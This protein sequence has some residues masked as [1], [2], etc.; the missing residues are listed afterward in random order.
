M[1]ASKTSASANAGLG[2]FP[3]D[4]E[5]QSLLSSKSGVVAQPVVGGTLPFLSFSNLMRIIIMTGL[6]ILYIERII[7]SI[8]IIPMAKMYGWNNT[9][10]GIVLASF[11]AGY[12]L[13]QLPTGHFVNRF[14]GHR[15]MLFAMILP[16]VFT[17][18]TPLAA[19]INFEVLCA[20]RFLMGFWE[21]PIFPALAGL[22]ASWWPPQTRSLTVAVSYTG[23][24]LGTMVAMG[25][26]PVIID[27]LGDDAVY[28]V[29]G[30]LGLLIWTPIWMLMGSSTPF[31]NRFVSAA[32]LQWIAERMPTVALPAHV[33]VT[34]G[35]LSIGKDHGTRSGSSNQLLAS[36]SKRPIPWKQIGTTGAVW[37]IIVA[38]F[39]QNWLFYV[40]VSFLPKYF[41]ETFH[42]DLVVI[43]VLSFLPF[44]SMA[45]FA[46]PTGRMADHLLNTRPH[47]P[48]LRIRRTIQFI[49][50]FVPCVLLILLCFVKVEAA[51][52]VFVT[53]AVGVSGM[54]QAGFNSNVLDIS[55]PFSSVVLGMSNT[56]GTVPGI[57]GV[58]AA[59]VLLDAFH[60]WTPIFLGTAG[61]V[62]LGLVV[63]QTMSKAHTLFF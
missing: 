24:Y 39:S 14:G 30:G 29:A 25:I 1:C 5:E 58:V 2:P 34:N 32:E 36:K 9:Q 10:Q 42:M 50:F 26:S 55:G 43:G 57:V 61:V 35:R 6:M 17:I 20:C 41:K 49:A 21:G 27:S 7:M 33:T 4:A 56:A 37:A 46:V 28:Y 12:I 40:L 51:S 23:V 60:S 48:L 19:R 52:I 16:S 45:F 38:N 22:T 62:F 44:I 63:F 47:I 3:S 15:V 8:T 11:Y 59:G 13:P 18:L 31:D 54:C 53:F